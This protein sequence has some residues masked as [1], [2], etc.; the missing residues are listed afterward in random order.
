MDLVWQAVGVVGA[1]IFY[2]RF[3]AQWIASEMAK[4][5]VVP[6]VFWYMSSAGSVLLM[7]Y[8]VY[9][10]SPLGV[11]GQCFNIVIYSRNLVHIWRRKRGLSKTELLAIHGVAGAVVLVAVSFAMLTWFREYE[12][13]Q[14]TE[15]SKVLQ[16]WL[17]LAIGVVGQ[18]LFAL[19][20]LIQWIATEKAKKSVVPTSFWYAS[21]GAAVLM[22]ASFIQH[23]DWVYAV[24][25]GTS[26][27]IY[28]RNLW[29][30]HVTGSA[31]PATDG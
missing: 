29:L 14:Q 21:V 2:G 16:A 30:I 9:S 26:L 18:A 19:R 10:Q 13:N 27:L 31:S 12:I 11:L 4:R 7:A 23:R 1:V 24:G 22:M 6:T 5:S 25:T 15:S 3:Y 28:L 17:W 8:G 20:F